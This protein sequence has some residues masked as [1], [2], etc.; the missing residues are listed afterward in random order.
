MGPMGLITA[1][2]LNCAFALAGL[3]VRAITISGAIAGI[4]I[5]TVI[6]VA[7]GF[8]AWA[9]LVTMF[10]LVVVATRAGASRTRV[11]EDPHRR[12]ERRGAGNAIANTGVAAIC[13]A[14]FYFS[15]WWPARVAM[16]AAL[17]ASGSD[18]VASEIGKAWGRPTWHVFRGAVTP[19][20][21]GGMS[22]AGTLAGAAT[23]V[24]LAAFSIA[25][26]LISP[27]DAPGVA[28]AST[29]AFSIEGVLISRLEDSGLV[30]NHT[31]NFAGSFVGASL[32]C[33]WAWFWS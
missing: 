32:A 16:A 5:G 25:L 19:G 18:S 22:A 27:T 31:V 2:A 11:P 17:I 30:G 7:S 4:A 8:G 20:T 9:L 23:A 21:P 10:A 28:L 15:Q 26:G 29:M 14:V 33:T 3:A 6:A 24:A 13:A 12:G 1:L